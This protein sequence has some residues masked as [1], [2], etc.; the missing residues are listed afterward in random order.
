MK[1]ESGGLTIGIREF[2]GEPLVIKHNYDKGSNE[3][4]ACRSLR[5]SR[6]PL[7]TKDIVDLHLDLK[8]STM[9]WSVNDKHAG[10]MKVR[11]ANYQLAV[12][13]GPKD[14]IKLLEP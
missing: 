11:P 8:K 10:S 9:S 1:E 2:N 5:R 3:Y 7:E 6:T 14:I 12:R 13:C 4:V